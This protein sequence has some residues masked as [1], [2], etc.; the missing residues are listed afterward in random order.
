MT[1]LLVV[2]LNNLSNLPK[3]M[4]AW[5]RIGVPGVTLLQSVGGF[6]AEN[7]L[8]RIGLGGFSR[9]FDSGEYRQRTL[10]SLIQGEEL[11]EQAIA[12]AELVVG[13]FDSPHSGILF[14][15]PV[16]KVLGLQKWDLGETLSAP[17][18]PGAARPID[19]GALDD[20]TRV[21]EIVDILHLDTAVVSVHASLPEVV[22]ALLANPNVQVACVVN[23]ENH[24]VGLIDTKTLANALFLAVFPEEFL[25]NLKNLEEVLSLADRRKVRQAADIMQEP[26]FLQMEDTLRE[27]F[28]R[29]HQSKLPGLPVVDHHY[30]IQGYIN[31][32]ELMAVFLQPGTGL[33]GG[34]RGKA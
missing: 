11:L 32:L 20:A 12:E 10:L 28:H 23:E 8:Q 14:T 30:H 1:Y 6:H 21:A 29:I 25:G 9:L 16:G 24:L 19:T 3:I 2:I 31:L 34:E 17:H 13:G 22:E 5:R 33:A 26:A 18:P 4:Q 27:A 15:V 7:W